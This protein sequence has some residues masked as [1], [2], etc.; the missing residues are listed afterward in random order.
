MFGTKCAFVHSDYRA[1]CTSS[2][3]TRQVCNRKG[4][5][6]VSEEIRLDQLKPGDLVLVH[7]SRGSYSK[8]TLHSITPA[9]NY[10]IAQ[11][12]MGKENLRI[13]NKNGIERGCTTWCMVALHVFNEQFWQEEL[14]RRKRVKLLTGIEKIIW[15]NLSTE[16][17]ENVLEDVNKDVAEKEFLHN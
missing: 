3:S 6:K 17:L 5:D 10:K 2:L 9:G 13:F 7:E 12:S 11:K 16:V 8:G 15:R 14:V 1:G 4:L